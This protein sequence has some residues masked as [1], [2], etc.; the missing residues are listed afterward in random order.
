[1]GESQ[2]LSRK[3]VTKEGLV[4]TVIRGKRSE[5]LSRRMLAIRRR[6]WIEGLSIL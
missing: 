4:Y 1:M 3:G 2:E 6:H 5:Q